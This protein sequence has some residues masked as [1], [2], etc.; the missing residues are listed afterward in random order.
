MGPYTDCCSDKGVA[1]ARG[2]G[3]YH[4]ANPQSQRPQGGQNLRARPTTEVPTGSLTT[5]TAG[6]R[7]EAGPWAGRGPSYAPPDP[8]NSSDGDAHVAPGA[9]SATF[10]AEGE[11]NGMR[12]TRFSAFGPG[13]AGV[14]ARTHHIDAAPPSDLGA[15]A[16]SHDGGGAGLHSPPR[17]EATHLGPPCAPGPGCSPEA[18][19]GGDVL[20]CSA[21][22]VLRMRSPHA[23]LAVE[24][25]NLT[26]AC[27]TDKG[28]A[29]PAAC[30]ALAARTLGD[31]RGT[32][33]L[34]PFV[35]RTFEWEV[36]IATF[37]P[38]LRI[39]PHHC[40]RL[41]YFLDPKWRKIEF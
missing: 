33:E 9:Q 17:R 27:C 18:P 37:V 10:D 16:Q 21:C 4:A 7:A 13:V 2:G 26:S 20:S 30:A 11:C 35:N 12:S 22:T 1:L 41:T 40:A 23:R 5:T 36:V 32:G 19:H 15:G 24:A 38:V 25:L 14:H 28:N 31:C 6:P 39:V 29:N 3:G 8:H 34:V